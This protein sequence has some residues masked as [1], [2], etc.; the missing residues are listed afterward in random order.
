MK[1]S[2]FFLMRYFLYEERKLDNMKFDEQMKAVT[3]MGY[4]VWYLGVT[5]EEVFICNG[6]FKQKVSDIYF[7]NI[8]ILS[9]IL[10]Y[11]SIYK[12]ALKILNMKSN[13]DYAYIRSSFPMLSFLKAIKKIKK[14]GTKTIME[15]PTYPPI[16]ESKADR[17]WWRKVMFT[18]TELI[19]KEV[20]KYIDLYTLI[21]EKGNI[22]Y[23]KT[24]INIENGL[25]INTLP[26]RIPNPTT[27]EIHLIALAKVARWHGFDRLIEGLNDYY[28]N[29]GRRN[30][31]LHIVGPD[32]DH[33]ME[34]LE[35]LVKE[36]DLKNNV[37]FE[38]PMYGE[39]LSNMINMCDIGVS[40]LGLYRI[41][42]NTTSVLKVREYMSR[43]IPFIYTGIDS[44]LDDNN[45]FHFKVPNDD[46]PIN[47]EK[48]INFSLLLRNNPLIP[49]K[50]REYAVKNMS[51]QQQF[52]RIFNEVSMSK[53]SR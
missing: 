10:T 1:E 34:H 7:N 46:S 52:T 48:V 47:I 37:I 28:K 6:E 25:N 18:T 36:Y 30:L 3:E 5:K 15:I 27:D 53:E 41:G 26:I 51:W 14:C 20:A 13:F 39:R 24:A 8:P 49:E 38:G 17:R 43:G 42:F 31:I 33:S 21:G 2:V 23:G 29:N 45:E 40:S 19:Q 50:M 16:K 44:A 4:D 22:Y 12:S 32:G 9:R 35:E 11:T